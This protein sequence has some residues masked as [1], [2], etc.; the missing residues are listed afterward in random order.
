MDIHLDTGLLKEWPAGGPKKL[1]TYGKA[2]LGY[3]GHIIVGGK[4]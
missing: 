2:G 1:W 3:S 4:L